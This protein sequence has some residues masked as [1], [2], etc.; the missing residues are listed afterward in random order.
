MTRVW[1]VEMQ[2]MKGLLWHPVAT[3]FKQVLAYQEM[4]AW[5]EA[6]PDDHY[7]V[8]EYVRRKSRHA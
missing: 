3:S 2:V 1:V 7:R 8:V 5:Q 6:N 4:R